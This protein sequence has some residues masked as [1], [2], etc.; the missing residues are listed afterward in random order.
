MRWGLLQNV[1]SPI[2]EWMTA[3]PNDRKKAAGFPYGMSA[4]ELLG[5]VMTIL[6]SLG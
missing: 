3:H 5:I 4:A 1:A 6:I 2:F